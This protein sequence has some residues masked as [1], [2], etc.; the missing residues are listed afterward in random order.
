MSKQH[1]MLA[2]SIYT[3]TVKHGLMPDAHERLDREIN[4]L[5][6]TSIRDLL[7]MILDDAADRRRK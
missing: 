7:H 4:T 6:H 3:D 2:L 1:L 5:T